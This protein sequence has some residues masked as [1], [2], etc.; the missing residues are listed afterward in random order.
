[1]TV[2]SENGEGRRGGS[3]LVVGAPTEELLRI[4]Q[5]LES[6]ATTTVVPAAESLGALSRIE[7][8]V[9]VVDE[10]NRA[11]LAETAALGPA[12]VR[13][14]LGSADGLDAET[15]ILPRPLDV[16]AVQ[17]VCAVALRAAKARRVACDL[18]SENQHLRNATPGAAT[19]TSEELGGLECYEGI[20]TQSSAMRRVLAL[21]RK[22]EGSD[23]TALIHGEAGSGK[24]LVAQAIHARS[25]SRRGRFVAVNL[26]AVADQLRESALFGHVRGAFTGASEDRTGLFVEANGGCIFLDEIGEASPGL[27]VALLRVLEEGIVTPVGSDRP[28]RVD[29]HVIAGSSRNLDEL[30]HHGLFRRDLYYRLNVFPIELPPLRHRPEDILPLAK[31]F[32]VQSSLAMGKKP[33]EIAREARTVLDA[34]QWEGN[35]REL[36]N[37]MERAA[38]LC[39]GGTVV[40]ADLPLAPERDLGSLPA[41]DSASTIVIPPGGA[42][43][44]QLEREI[45]QKTL[46]LAE[47][48]QSRA[49][50]ILGLR[51]STFRFRLQKLGIASRR[52]LPFRLGRVAMF[53]LTAFAE[54]AILS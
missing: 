25:R 11:L 4:A 17:A 18:E 16:Q 52:S 30:A 27:Q 5:A 44:D 39:K 9:L 34:Y 1:M 48:N 22:I 47:Y 10:P 23:T 15:V 31:H 6:L 26:G 7:P 50:R 35:V 45:F 32:L 29:V 46:A 24:E 38:I 28:R 20:L 3:I 43:L 2:S 53:L 49:A 21:L 36:R 8:D 51:E 19:L 13:I 42:K 14:L 12:A 54:F 41:G 40:A 33:P 37:V